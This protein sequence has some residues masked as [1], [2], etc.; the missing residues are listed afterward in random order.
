ML[1][2]S[3]VENA[4]YII[5]SKDSRLISGAGDRIYARGI[6]PGEDPKS[7]YAVLRIGK[8]YG[9]ECLIDFDWLH[10]LRPD[11]ATG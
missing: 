8:A 6:R 10:Y 3:E 2:E 7:N 5:S 9:L 4:A 11:N 1:S